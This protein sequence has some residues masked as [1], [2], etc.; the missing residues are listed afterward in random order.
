MHAV[1]V[2]MIVLKNNYDSGC[3]L[4]PWSYSIGVNTAGISRP[5]VTTVLLTGQQDDRQ[6]D[7]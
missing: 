1:V 5:G 7:L 2:K 6:I 4:S 3:D